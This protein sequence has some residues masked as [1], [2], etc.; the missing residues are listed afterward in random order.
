MPKLLTK[1]LFL[2]IVIVLFSFNST[3]AFAHDIMMM[4]SSQWLF[5]Q[6]KIEVNL[7]LF[8]APLYEV[9]EIITGGFKLESLTNEELKQVAH[10]IIQPYINKKLSILINDKRYPVKISNIVKSGTSLMKI[11]L[12]VDNFILE[13][14]INSVKIDYK[15]FFEETN[16]EHANIAYFFSSNQSLDKYE[17]TFTSFS[18]LWEGKLNNSGSIISSSSDNL[19]GGNNSISSKNQNNSASNNSFL[20]HAVQFILLGI[21]H[22]LI[23]YDHILFLLALIVIGLSF[24]ETLGII[25]AFTV[26]HSITLFL[27]V[28]QIVKLNPRFVE[29][30][31][32]LSI[33]YVAFENIFRKKINHRWVLAFGFG[34][35]HG[36]GFAS[37][38]Q[39]FAIDKSNLIYIILS[40]NIGVEVG[41]L[42]VLLFILPI[43]YLLRKKFTFK[44]ITE[45]VSIIVFIFG[46]DRLIERAFNIKLP[47]F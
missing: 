9:K 20:E 28:L 44:S 43:L 24:K 19:S 38:L 47:G 13:K 2:F 27:A 36:F 10:K 22:I 26:A 33:C 6:N 17:Y 18:S 46:F 21:K 14:E 4:G 7:E 37:I 41:Q 8:T 35:I 5:K 15:L 1:K 3:S 23:G 25:T 39:E 40:F 11:S 29:S 34:L 30:A 12:I 32:A 16:N 31:I 45:N 42:L